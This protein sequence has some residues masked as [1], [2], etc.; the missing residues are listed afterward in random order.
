MVPFKGGRSVEPNF[1][2]G[3]NGRISVKDIFKPDVKIDRVFT[4]MASPCWGTAT[5]E[6]KGRVQPAAV[7]LADGREFAV[8]MVDNRPKVDWAGLIKKKELVGFKPV[9]F[10]LPADGFVSLVITD[11]E[12]TVVRHLLN[13][14]FYTAGKH[15][16][17]WDG[18]GDPVFRT[19]GDPVAAGQYQYKVLFHRGLGLKFRGFAGCD[20]AEPWDSG[21]T[22]G[23]GGDHGV[24]A[25]AVASGKT[26]YLGWSGAE[27]GKAILACDLE[28]KILWRNIRGGIAGASILA[29]DGND[30]YV[31]N[32]GTA[33]YRLTADKG[34]YVFWEGTESADLSLEPFVPGAKSVDGL[35][36]RGGKLYLSF[37]NNNF[38]AVADGKSGKLLEKLEIPAP[39]QLAFAKDGKLLALSE[40]KAVLALDV[41]SGASQPLVSGLGAAT[42]LTVD[43]EGRIYVGGDENQVK[44]FDAAGG[45][46]LSI[47]KKGGRPARGVWQPEGMARIA[48]LAVDADGKLWVMEGTEGPKR[49]SV[50]EAKSGTLLKQLFGPTH[51]GASGGAVNP[52]DPDLMVGEGCEWRIDPKTG[53]GTCTGVIEERLAGFARFATPANGRLYL[54]T[55]QSM[56]K[57]GDYRI[58]ERVGEGDYRFRSSIVPNAAGTQV[59]ADQNGD[60][61]VQENEVS[62]TPGGFMASGYIGVSAFVNT[63]LSIIGSLGGRGVWLKPTGFTSC[64]AP[65]YDF[66]KAQK[67]PAVGQPSLDNRFVLEWSDNWISCFDAASGKKRWSYP[68][69]FSGVHGSHAA[70][71]PELGLLRGCFGSVGAAHLPAA[72]AVWAMNGNC[73]EWYLFT[74]DGF[75]LAQ[76]FQ[77]DNTKMQ[78]PEKAV[79]GASL[80][81]CPP[82]LGGEDFGGSMTQGKDGKVYVQ[83]GKIGLWNVE[84]TG[85]ETIQSLPGGTI[86]L[87]QNDTKQAL[88]F[89]DKAVQQAAGTKQV[90]LARM[91]PAFTG[92]LDDDFR[93]AP[94]LAFKKQDDAAVRCAAAFDASQ[95][96][97]GWDVT[98]KTPWT[99]GATESDQLYLSG[100]TVD[101]Q[102]GTDPQAP[103]DRAEAVAGDL[104]IS[105][106]NFKGKPTAVL[107]RRVSADKKPKSFQSGVVKD[108]PMDYVAEIDA[109]I[110]VKGK[111][112]RGYVVEA[113]IPLST[114]GIK[115]Q[116]AMTLTGDFGVTHGD[117]GGQRTRLRSYWSNQAT[118]IVDDAVFELKME[119]KNWGKI[120]LP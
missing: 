50:W 52:L 23:W 9:E 3:A 77:G 88:A 27:A 82:G 8:A 105:I 32:P 15:T 117:A 17:N 90:T 37:A 83:A 40:G 7:R 5:L 39:G 99:N 102:L 96:Y 66:T 33:V 30:L 108:Y 116:D 106:G 12:G 11:G 86:S 55:G 10:T 74:G 4:F 19:P 36:A 94:V 114:L 60:G 69:T 104:R 49:V 100:D 111:E 109:K 24:P 61:Q 95:L 63:D 87:D 42:A 115:L 113:A 81:N 26:V 78:W 97:V 120:L 112:N 75:F 89:R 56:Y 22:S 35:A 118:G 79:P 51:Y 6:A 18:T 67:A 20:G 1:T 92:K 28:G 31:L 21:P 73:G 53:R 46:L 80:D 62:V 76:L 59:W 93:G 65:T 38:I 14:A 2:I 107:Y 103:K 16:V 119:P 91:T 45:N 48:G 13:S 110:E 98:D 64:G 85:L 57:P 70:P 68:N 101:L 25:A 72:G 29:L 58:Y 43:A 54:V 41:E 44:V 84:V 34:T 47:G 71:G